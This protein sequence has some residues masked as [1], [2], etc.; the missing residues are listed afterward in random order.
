MDMEEAM[1]QV[2]NIK[3]IVVEPMVMGAT[4]GIAYMAT[5]Y[6]LK[7]KLLN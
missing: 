1:E 6:I 3:K 7:R 4:F 5:F 2:R